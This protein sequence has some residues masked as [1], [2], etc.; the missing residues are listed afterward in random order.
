MKLTKGQKIARELGDMPPN[1][2]NPDTYRHHIYRHVSETAYVYPL[3][4]EWTVGTQ[5]VNLGSNTEASVVEFGSGDPVDSDV[6]LI[7]K[8]IT[9]DSGGYSIKPSRSM[10]EMQYDMMGSAVVLGAMVDSN[11]PSNVTAIIP[12]AENRISS[13]AMLPGHVIEYKDGTRVVVEN[14]DAEG[15]LLLADGIIRAVHHRPKVIITVATLT[16]AVVGALGSNTVGVFSTDSSLA[17]LALEAFQGSGIAGWT[18]PMLEKECLKAITRPRGLISNSA[19]PGVPGHSSAA[20]FLNQFTDGITLLHLDIAG[21]AWD[22]KG[23]R[24]E[25]VLVLCNLLKKLTEQE[26]NHD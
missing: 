13:N 9:F 2:L 14:T 4:P 18:L 8:G 15:R 19:S 17:A 11:F 10:H 25:M 26:I 21:V 5:A 6:F 7:G 23:A 16:G 12:I 22:K 1:V 3:T 20:T 24:T